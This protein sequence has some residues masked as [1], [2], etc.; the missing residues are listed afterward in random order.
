LPPRPP[1]DVDRE[2]SGDALDLPDA[3]AEPRAPTGDRIARS[4][5]P[6]APAVNLGRSGARPTS[7]DPLEKSKPKPTEAKHKTTAPAPAVKAA[8]LTPPEANGAPAANPP[9]RADA[10]G[11][12][13]AADSPLPEAPTAPPPT[14]SKAVN[15]L[16]VTPLD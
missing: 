7:P 4:D 10:P 16:P 11:S 5:D 14:K 2:G 12:V 1:A 13:A 15:D 9:P 3:R 8:A 6:A